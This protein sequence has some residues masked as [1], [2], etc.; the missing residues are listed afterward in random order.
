M[1]K[2]QVEN[3]ILWS[4]IRSAPGP[5]DRTYMDE[6]TNE[7]NK[8]FILVSHANSADASECVLS[9]R[10]EITVAVACPLGKRSLIDQYNRTK[11]KKAYFSRTRTCRRNGTAKNT[12]KNATPKL[13]ITS[14]PQFK[15]NG[16]PSAGS[17]NF[18]NAGIMPTSPAARGIVPTATA[19]VCTRTF[20][21][22]EKG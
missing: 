9:C 13:H 8:D 11:G 18:S 5:R 22:G 14:I 12:P 21:T 15:S 2:E 20:S 7:Y 17:N 6:N 10:T 16:P 3:K 1:M 4:A 19:T